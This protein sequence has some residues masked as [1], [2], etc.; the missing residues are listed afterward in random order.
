[1]GMTVHSQM[2][3]NFWLKNHF[4]FSHSQL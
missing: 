1:L 2:V 3:M 4:C